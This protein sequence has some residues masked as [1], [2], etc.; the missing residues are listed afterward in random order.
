MEPLKLETPNSVTWRYAKG[1]GFLYIPLGEPMPSLT[2]DLG[3]G[4]LAH[5]SKDSVEITGFTMLGVSKGV[6]GYGD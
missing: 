1:A 5:Y 3:G 4:P 2:Q 6:G